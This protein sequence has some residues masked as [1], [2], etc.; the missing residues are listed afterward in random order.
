MSQSTDDVVIRREGRAGRITMNRPKALNA[1][2]YGMMMEI[3]RALLA[4]KD[5]PR[6]ALILLDGAGDKAL[7]AG[8]DVRALYDS[9]AEGPE[10]ARRFWADEYRLNALI[11]RY[12]KPYVAFMDGIVMGGGIGLSAH[13]S[14]RIVTERSQLAMPETTIGLVPDVGGTWLLAHM[15]GESGAYCGMLGHRMNAG[16]ALYA[17]FADTM[18][19]SAKLGELAHVLCN[20]QEPVAVTI[21]GFAAAPQPSSLADHAAAIDG[22]FQHNSAEAIRDT[23]AA[24]TGE[25]AA[26]ALADFAPRSP[27]ALKATLAAVR[28]ARTLPSLEAALQIEYRLTTRLF[29]NGEFP[30]GIR[31]LIVDK[32]KSPKWK[33]ARLEDVGKDTVDALFAPLPD[34]RDL[35]LTDPG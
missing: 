16:D 24:A 9:R 22:A 23:L 10:F 34:G 13:A 19:P 15:P 17:G 32:D 29:E 20:T 14:H 33:Y 28:H 1:L 6:V 21:A 8:G 12:P 27:L 31:A 7:C 5:D 11:G 25:W 2:T 4:W 35:D 30:E 18:V 26:K 3:E